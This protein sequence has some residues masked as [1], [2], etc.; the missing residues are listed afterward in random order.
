V[1]LNEHNCILRPMGVTYIL[2]QMT[3]VVPTTHSGSQYFHA[4]SNDSSVSSSPTH[5]I[6]SIARVLEVDVAEI[7]HDRPCAAGPIKLCPSFGQIR[8]SA[9]RSHPTVRSRL[10]PVSALS[11][12]IKDMFLMIINRCV[13][14]QVSFHSSETPVNEKPRPNLDFRAFFMFWMRLEASRSLKSH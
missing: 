3:Q 14:P 7:C 8:N 1:T 6:D 2:V 11:G 9:Q 12:P 5:L 10:S 4:T 13:L